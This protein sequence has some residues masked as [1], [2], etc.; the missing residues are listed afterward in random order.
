LENKNTTENPEVDSTFFNASLN[1]KEIWA[2]EE[3]HATF[4]EGKKFSRWLTVSADTIHKQHYPSWYT[5]KVGRVF[6]KRTGLMRGSTDREPNRDLCQH[7]TR[8]L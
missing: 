4:S 3:I 5:T 2:G 8:W 1:G 6:K 7:Q